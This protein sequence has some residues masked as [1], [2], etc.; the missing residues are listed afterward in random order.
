[1]TTFELLAELSQKI[2]SDQ[3][4][5]QVLKKF[6]GKALQFKLNEG[7]NFYV[8]FAEDGSIKLSDGAAQSPNATVSGADQLIADII[9][10]KT[11]PV[12]SMFLGKL[13][14]SGDLL[15]AQSLVNE[16]KKLVQ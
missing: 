16:V 3:N 2:N 14:V 1:M 10:G 5:K 8:V 13:K 6:A 7:R 9:L 15:F 4:K 12:R 11:D